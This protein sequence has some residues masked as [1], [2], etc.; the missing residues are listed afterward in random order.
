M[1]S[2]IWALVAVFIFLG[3]IYYTIKKWES[4]GKKS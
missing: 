1:S 4:C 3:F 2:A